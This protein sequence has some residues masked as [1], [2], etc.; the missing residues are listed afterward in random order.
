M[1]QWCVVQFAEEDW[2]IKVDM[3]N[4]PAAGPRTTGSAIEQLAA[5]HRWKMLPELEH[6]SVKISDA[7]RQL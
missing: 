4:T 5:N 1:E 3:G 6:V 2:R 7:E